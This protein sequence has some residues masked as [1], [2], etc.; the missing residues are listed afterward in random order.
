MWAKSPRFER[1]KQ[2]DPNVLSN[3]FTKLVANLPKRLISLYM[4]F[5]TRHISLNQHLHRIKR[6]ITPNC[7]ICADSE[8]TIHHFLFVCPQYDR[9]RFV[10]SRK[11]GRKASSLPFLLTDP[12]AMEHFLRYVNST[13]R[14]KS[15]FGEV[16]LPPAPVKQ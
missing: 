9:E 8:E 11:L 12:S 3:S 13:G 10:L 1:T 6:S 16:L 5:R 14:L 4:Y 7:P 2:I 15:S